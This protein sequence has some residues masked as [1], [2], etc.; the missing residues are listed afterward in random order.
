MTRRCC[1]HIALCEPTALPA[2]YTAKV[3]H[4]LNR[5]E[6]THF[7]K[8][9]TSALHII[10]PLPALLPMPHLPLL[11][12]HLSHPASAFVADYIRILILIAILNH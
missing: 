8:V 3:Y 9:A 12:C 5:E 10:Q 11:L 4:T 2:Y 1:L 7:G 6:I